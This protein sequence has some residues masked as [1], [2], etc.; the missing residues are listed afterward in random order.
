VDGIDHEGPLWPYQ[1][2]AALLRHE[3]AG[4]PPHARLPSVRHLGQR[5]G[6][7]PKTVAKALDAL[8]AEGLIY[9]VPSRGSYVKPR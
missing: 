5:H 9:R 1:Q 2:L 7:S 3:I 4:M 8:A 6:L